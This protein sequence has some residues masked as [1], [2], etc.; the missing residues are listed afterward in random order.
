M[1]DDHAIVREGL[2]TLLK[3]HERFVVVGEARDGVEAIEAVELHR[4]DVLLLDV[5]MPRM[6]GI[7]AAGKSAGGGQ[8]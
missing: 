7:E 8:S 5:N 6:N 2:I 4:P 1:A 3:E